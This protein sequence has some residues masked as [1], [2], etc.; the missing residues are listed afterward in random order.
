MLIRPFDPLFSLEQLHTESLD[1]LI[2]A[3]ELFLARL[4]VQVQ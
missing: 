2:P 1:L 4:Q 3:G